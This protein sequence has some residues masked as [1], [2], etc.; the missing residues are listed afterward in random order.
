[1][2]I[3]NNMTLSNSNS[4]QD[5]VQTDRGADDLSTNWKTLYN[6]QLWTNSELRRQIIK[7]P[8][9]EN[10]AISNCY[11]CRGK[12]RNYEI[13]SPCV[14]PNFLPRS[15][16]TPKCNQNAIKN[17][18]LSLHEHF[19][20]IEEEHDDAR[21]I[22]SISRQVDS[23][24]R[25]KYTCSTYNS[26][27]SNLDRRRLRKSLKSLRSIL[28][29][30]STESLTEKR[31]QLKA[32]SISVMIVAV[33]VICLVLVNFSTPSFVRAQNSTTVVPSVNV[34]VNETSSAIIDIH[35]N[36]TTY[37]DVIES[38]TDK[39]LST[40]E[41]IVNEA[42]AKLRKNIKTYPK[43][44]P[45][46]ESPKEIIN[47]DLS[48]KF[49]ACQSD[50]VCMLEE[51]SG[52]SICKIA[53]DIQDPTGCGGLCALETEACQLV[54][55]ERG[56]RVCRLLTLETCSPQ[57]WRCRNGLCVSVGARCDGT[58]QCYDRSDE[59]QC[60][61]DLTKQFRCGHSLSCFPNKKLC[62]GVID[63]W[64]GFDEVNCT[65]ECSDDQFP[66][67]NGQCIV[68]SRFCDG[69]ADCA[70]GSDEPHGCDAACGAHELKCVNQR[71]VSLELRCNNRDDCGDNTDEIQCS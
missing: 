55:K 16:S 13:T 2:I 12:I 18:E 38:T 22:P 5:T 4:N 6:S 56:I 10:R 68:S 47:R 61:C 65:M 30:A 25:Q 58:I 7:T 40:T 52:T 8:F 63:C 15:H 17:I 50:E 32:C 46:R 69:F 24:F 34:D 20:V 3:S 35:S 9:I 28:N 19:A 59:K 27:N 43:I 51:E 36:P 23:S 66:C 29:F 33:V 54:D 53:T 37:N 11:T 62:D 31:T 21:N 39:L 67:N 26:P 70:D 57:D 45:I 48:Q 64:D 60:E 14:D 44:K 71:C 1:M 49:C 41:L 42:I